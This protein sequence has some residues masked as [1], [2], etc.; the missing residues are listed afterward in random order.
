M[1][2]GGHLALTCCQASPSPCPRKTKRS[3]TSSSRCELLALRASSW[4]CPSSRPQSSHVAMVVL[5]PCG[6]CVTLC[7]ARLAPPRPLPH[8]SHWVAPAPLPLSLPLA[9]P[10]G[11]ARLR[12]L[13]WPALGVPG[14]ARRPGGAGLLPAGAVDGWVVRRRVVQR[15]VDGRVARL[16]VRG[17]WLGRALFAQRALVC[18]ALVS[19]ARAP[20][21]GALTW[22]SAHESGQQLGRDAGDTRGGVGPLLLEVGRCHGGRRFTLGTQP[23]RVQGMRIPPPPRTHTWL[24]TGGLRWD[25]TNPN[26]WPL[27]LYQEAV[28]ESRRPLPSSSGAKRQV[29]GP[30]I[31]PDRWHYIVCGSGDSLLCVASQSHAGAWASHCEAARIVA[32]WPRCHC[33]VCVGAWR[34]SELLDFRCLRMALNSQQGITFS[35]RALWGGRSPQALL[36]SLKIHPHSRALQFHPLC[37]TS[38]IAPRAAG[39]GVERRQPGA[40]GHAARQGVPGPGGQ[41]GHPKVRGWAGVGGGLCVGC[42][43]HGVAG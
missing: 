6:S 17:C 20:G 5:L 29:R 23:L 15:R 8:V 37:S 28:A 14:P 11:H 32:S 34:C 16:C 3:R 38:Q 21:S 19:C 40:H 25:V 36:E 13:C 27:G 31:F 9:P 22:H 35:A 30:V 24:H 41:G 26:N 10:A 12:L 33:S 2:D 42:E 1:P 18:A 39:T 4:C 7:L 43:R